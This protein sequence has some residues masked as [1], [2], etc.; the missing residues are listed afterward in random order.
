[1]IK[2]EIGQRWIP[3]ARLTFFPEFYMVVSK[4]PTGDY[5]FV[6]QSHSGIV[7]QVDI[8]YLNREGKLDTEY[9]FFRELLE[10]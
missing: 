8:E 3:K 5:D 7:E 1:M 10:L 4:D 2:V 6:V 9:E